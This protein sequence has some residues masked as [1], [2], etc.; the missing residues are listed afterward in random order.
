MVAMSV[1][2]V[3]AVAMV[4]VVARRIVMA[5]PVDTLHMVARGIH[6]VGPV[7][8]DN[9]RRM[10]VVAD[11][12]AR[13]TR[14]YRDHSPRLAN[15]RR[16]TAGGG[17]NGLR[18]SRI[19]LASRRSFG[20]C[21]LGRRSFSLR[22]LGL[23]RFSRRRLCLRRIRRRRSRLRDCGRMAVQCCLSSEIGTLK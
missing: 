20:R 17:D 15:Y 8:L 10:A 4:A 7:V 3:T 5:G 19:T 1:V 2:T 11:H 23:R 13:M 22:R 16:L 21:S 6:V 12:M 18:S 9:P 14:D